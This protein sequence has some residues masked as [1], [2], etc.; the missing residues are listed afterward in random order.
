MA[1]LGNTFQQLK[2]ELQKTRYPKLQELERTQND[3]TKLID[4]MLQ[5]QP[6]TFLPFI[7]HALLVFSP[8][9]AEYVTENGFDLYAKSDYRFIESVYKL[10]I[11]HFNYKATITI[12]QFFAQGYC[13]PKMVFCR[14]ICKMMREKNDSLA[15][16]KAQNKYKVVRHTP[17]E[18]S[19]IFDEEVPTP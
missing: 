17:S 11:I 19:T 6:F 12:Q 15:K 14:D 2:Y 7:H 9:V 5:G 18:P 10:L 16:V 13:E 3:G 1:D 8:D 4:M